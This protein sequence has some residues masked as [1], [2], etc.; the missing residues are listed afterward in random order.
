MNAANKN[1]FLALHKSQSLSSFFWLSLTCLVLVFSLGSCG[2]KKKSDSAVQA[3]APSENMNPIELREYIES[4]LEGSDIKNFS[5]NFHAI[6]PAF[7]SLDE[8]GKK[9]AIAGFAISVSKAESSFN[10]FTTFFE[11][12]LG[13][14]SVGLF[15]LSYEDNKSYGCKFNKEADAGLAREEKTIHRTDVQVECFL[16]ITRRLLTESEKFSYLK[17]LSKTDKST[18]GNPRLLAVHQKLSA[19]WSV[20]RTSNKTGNTRYKKALKDFLPQACF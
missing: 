10:S 17:K 12:G 13:F 14:N 20:L 15:A 3:P 6:C 2:K 5:Q 19:Y 8:A 16:K 4:Q 1:N 18:N 11:T 7:E 9:H